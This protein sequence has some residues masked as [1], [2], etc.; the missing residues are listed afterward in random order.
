MEHHCNSSLALLSLILN[1]GNE[2]FLAGFL[3]TQSSNSLP[4]MCYVSGCV[5]VCC[6]CCFFF[7]FFSICTTVL[8]FFSSLRFFSLFS[9]CNVSWPKNPSYSGFIKMSF[10]SECF[11]TYFLE[12]VNQTFFVFQ[13]L[14][15][16]FTAGEEQIWSFLLTPNSSSDNFPTICWEL[17]L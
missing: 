11:L 13:I 12:T 8:I 5:L 14:L 3:N 6:L 9:S 16:S 17:A 7:F 1:F 2:I 15:F 10:C 4:Q